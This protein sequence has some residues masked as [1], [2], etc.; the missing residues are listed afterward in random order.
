DIIAEDPDTHGSFLVAVI[1]GSDKT[2][3][4]VGTGNIEYHP[5]YISIGNIHNN[6]RRAH[7]NG[8]VLLGFL[9]I[10]K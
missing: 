1:A 8:V 5:I 7:R 10:P 4:S 2:T 3:V 6:T 9:P